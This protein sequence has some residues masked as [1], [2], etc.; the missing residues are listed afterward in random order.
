MFWLSKACFMLT[1]IVKMLCWKLEI[2]R[3]C[4]CK[5]ETLGVTRG[6]SINWAGGNIG[7]N[8][9][10][11]RPIKNES[12]IDKVAS[13]ATFFWN[14]WVPFIFT[15]QKRWIACDLVLSLQK[16]PHHLSM[17]YT[18]NNCSGV[19]CHILEYFF[20]NSFVGIILVGGKSM[21]LI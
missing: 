19:W 2:V 21:L 3:H 4:F 12:K 14:E 5:V 7:K 16:L 17:A 20:W 1:K 9:K 6:W 13:D 18:L 8:S 11:A 10:L 15:N